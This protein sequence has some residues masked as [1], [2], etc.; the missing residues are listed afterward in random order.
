MDYLERIEIVE[1]DT[2][3]REVVNVWCPESAV[4]VAYIVPSHIVHDNLDM[5]AQRKSIYA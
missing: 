4:P 3:G 2:I 5:S 1:D